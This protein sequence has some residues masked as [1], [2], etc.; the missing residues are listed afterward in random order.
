MTG[1]RGRRANQSGGVRFKDGAWRIR[2]RDVDGAQREKVVDARNKRQ[3]EGKLFEELERVAKEKGRGAVR[4]I[5]DLKVY[6]R[7]HRT[8]LNK[9]VVDLDKRWL[10]LAD[11]FGPLDVNGVSSVHLADYAEHRSTHSRRRRGGSDAV[12]KS[13]INRELATL[14]MLLRAGAK[15]T[16]P[17]VRW[18]CIPA[19]ELAD[20]SDRVREVFIDEDVWDLISANLA[21]HLRPPLTLAYWIGWRRGELLGLLRSQV[22]LHRGTI[23]LGS[24]TTK[25]KQ[26]RLIYI[27]AEALAEL[28]AWD[29]QTRTLERKLQRVIPWMF[30]YCGER[31]TSY[32][33]GWTAALRRAGLPP[34]SYRPHDFRR[35]AAR[36]YTRAGV[37]DQ[38]TMR[39]TGHK[40][41][42]MLHRYNITA[43]RDLAEA[44]TRVS[45]EN[46]RRRKGGARAEEPK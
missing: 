37:T 23:R 41:T 17:I 46:R 39:I 36:A 3:A 4:T 31:I 22:D 11:F 1:K 8:A 30:H 5:A 6:V 33:T 26:G 20:E 34:R 28:R 21:D 25:N 18:E 43:Q 32:Y 27:P 15:A 10:S 42:A 38:V 9:S 7:R 45:R 13:T 16:P 40:T 19:I 44:A 12:S 35:T 2:F 24:G 29:R 14:R